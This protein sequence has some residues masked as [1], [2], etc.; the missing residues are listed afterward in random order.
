MSCYNC[1]NINY[2]SKFQNTLDDTYSN[3]CTYYV[4]KYQ[5]N[6]I[7]KIGGIDHDQF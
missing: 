2:C 5:V 7:S 1:D 3:T 4:D 6:Y